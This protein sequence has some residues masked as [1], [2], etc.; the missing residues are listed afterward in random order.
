MDKSRTIGAGVML[1]V[2]QEAIELSQSPLR[3]CRLVC[4]LLQER[5]PE[6]VG[7]IN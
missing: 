7:A 1:K 4:E 2:Y 3:C 6:L 5:L